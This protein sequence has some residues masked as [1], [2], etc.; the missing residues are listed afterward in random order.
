M[1]KDTPLIYFDRSSFRVLPMSQHLLPY[2]LQTSTGY[3]NLIKWCSNRVVPLDR[4][5][6]KSLLNALHLPQND[7]FNVSLACRCLSLIDCYWV[8]DTDN[9]ENWDSINLY[10]NSFSEAISCLAFTGVSK[11]TIKKHYETPELTLNGSY[12]KCWRRINSGTY[13]YKANTL[14]GRESEREYICSLI[15]EILE[16]AHAPYWMEIYEGITSSVCRLITNEDFSILPMMEFYI[17]CQ[18]NNMDYLDYILCNYPQQF[19]QMMLFDGIVNNVDRHFNNWGFYI[20]NKD[21]TIVGLH[22][23]FDHN[24]ALDTTNLNVCSQV[25]NNRTLLECSKYAYNKLNRP[26]QIYTLLEWLKTHKTKKLFKSLFDGMAE[27]ELVY[28]N[29]NELLN[30]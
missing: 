1:H 28:N 12:A 6:A 4:L 22:P 13:L 24:C 30:S 9:W 21:N 3:T 5:H 2:V 25:F 26:I 11:V 7:P 8:K 20:D 14:Y 10:T 23:L 16:I 29:V 18:N 17:Y 19:Y 15:L 27:W